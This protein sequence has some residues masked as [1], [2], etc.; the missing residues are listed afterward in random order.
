M[1]TYK[2]VLWIFFIW[3]SILFV[4]DAAEYDYDVDESQNEYSN[5]NDFRSEQVVNITFSN[6]TSNQTANNVDYEANMP[7]RTIDG[8]DYEAKIPSNS[9]TRTPDNN[10]LIITTNKPLLEPTVHDHATIMSSTTT[11]TTTTME[12]VT[13]ASI[14]V[15]HTTNNPVSSSM[16]SVK[17]ESEQMQMVTGADVL[18]RVH[19]QPTQAD[20]T[21]TMLATTGKHNHIN[22][23]YSI[24]LHINQ[25][26]NLLLVLITVALAAL[27]MR[28]WLLNRNRFQIVRF[29][30]G[31]LLF[32]VLIVFLLSLFRLVLYLI[33][34]HET[35]STFAVA[36]DQLL[37]RTQLFQIDSGLVTS[38]SAFIQYPVFYLILFA[39]IQFYDELKRKQRTRLTIIHRILTLNNSLILSIVFNFIIICTLFACFTIFLPKTNL[40]ETISTSVFVGYLMVLIG[41]VVFFLIKKFNLSEDHSESYMNSD[42]FL[43]LSNSVHKVHLKYTV[44]LIISI[45]FLLAFIICELFLLCIKHVCVDRCPNFNFSFFLTRCLTEFFFFFFVLIFLFVFLAAFLKFFKQ[46][47]N[48]YKRKKLYYGDLL[49]NDN[50]LLNEYSH[51]TRRFNDPYQKS[52]TTSDNHPTITNHRHM[53]INLKKSN[54]SSNYM[55]DMALIKDNHKLPVDEILPLNKNPNNLVTFNK[56]PSDFINNSKA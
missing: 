55:K 49:V 15:V 40:N 39:F 10:D 32:I 3:S 37:F 19:Q 17:Y 46:L 42:D 29:Y 47:S 31:Y 9:T 1:L 5:L 48:D 22:Y 41:F 50:D 34:R 28:I 38:T 35:L 2:Q 54:E 33:N 51:L 45:L 7:N 44:L 18:Q 30:L 8:I 16:P 25:L 24:L 53:L 23:F 43:N 6:I 4:L 14:S 20:D 12:P 27:L 21:T 56:N 52:S 26:I 13:Y 11:Q 36:K